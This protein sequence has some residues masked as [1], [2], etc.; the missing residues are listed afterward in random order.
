MKSII[1]NPEFL[2]ELLLSFNCI[3]SIFEQRNNLIPNNILE[4]YNIRSTFWNEI[5]KL[6][7]YKLKSLKNKYDVKNRQTWQD[8][9]YNGFRFPMIIHFNIEYY[10]NYYKDTES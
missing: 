5:V 9:W 1:Y 4:L 10:T 2:E 3:Y 6:R 8:I 7:Q